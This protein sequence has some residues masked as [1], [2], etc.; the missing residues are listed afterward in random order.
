LRDGQSLGRRL[1]AAWHGWVGEAKFHAHVD[2]A[3]ALPI[4]V[5]AGCHTPAIA[6]PRVEHAFE[7]LRR[8]PSADPWPE[9]TQADLE[10]WMAG[11]LAG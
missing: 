1:V 10:Q 2:K 3:Q 9:F 5:L 7:L 6:G 11:P 4:T 8:V